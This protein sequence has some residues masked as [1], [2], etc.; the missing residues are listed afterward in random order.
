MGCRFLINPSFPVI[1]SEWEQWQTTLIGQIAQLPVAETIAHGNGF[2]DLVTFH[3]DALV[4]I[5][6]ARTPE[7]LGLGR[8]EYAVGTSDLKTL[9]VHIAT[10]ATTLVVQVNQ[11]AVVLDEHV[12]IRRT[13]T[14]KALHAIGLVK[15]QEG[16]TLAHLLLLSRVYLGRLVRI[17]GI[18]GTYQSAV[19]NNL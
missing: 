18:V 6:S 10:G 1:G 19:G 4:P 8:M 7:V 11:H 9:D 13:L 15:R 2:L 12:F 16:Q 5:D 14:D 17:D 3:N